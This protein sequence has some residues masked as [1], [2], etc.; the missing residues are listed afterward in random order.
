MIF[1]N[2]ILNLFI[3]VGEFLCDLDIGKENRRV[4]DLKF[5]IYRF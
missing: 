3:K 1:L 4:K 2:D 5:V